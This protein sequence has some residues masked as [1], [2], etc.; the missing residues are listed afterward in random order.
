M[1]EHQQITAGIELIQC[2]E[3]YLVLRIVGGVQ[4]R[5][6]CLLG[7]GQKQR[8]GVVVSDKLALMQVETQPGAFGWNVPQTI[9]EHRIDPWLR[10]RRKCSPASR[11]TSAEILFC[12]LLN[13]C[14]LTSRLRTVVPFNWSNKVSCSA[15]FSRGKASTKML[16]CLKQQGQRSS[17]Q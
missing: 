3:K 10:H 6:H 13:A 16:V 7:T 11:K 17:Y 8:E 4:A 14:V 9:P 5:V 2:L 1:V 15:C 12:A